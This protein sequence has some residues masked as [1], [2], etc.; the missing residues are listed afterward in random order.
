MPGTPQSS[1]APGRAHRPFPA[2][3]LAFEHCPRGPSTACW[4]TRPI[5]NADSVVQ[6][7]DQHSLKPSPRLDGRLTKIARMLEG[8][9]R[10]IAL[11]VA[12]PDDHIDN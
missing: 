9:R 6:A 5:F 1:D 7:R 12:G 4:A 2:R 3:L 8:P 11:R 10:P